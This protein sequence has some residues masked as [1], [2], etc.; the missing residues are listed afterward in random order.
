MLSTIFCKMLLINNRVI[1]IYVLPVTNRIKTTL[2]R[3]TSVILDGWA[4]IHTIF[5][6]VMPTRPDMLIRGYA[7]F[8]VLRTYKYVLKAYT[9][10]LAYRRCFFCVFSS[11]NFNF[12]LE[13][14]F[15]KPTAFDMTL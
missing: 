6:Y 15:D 10:A 5:T 14:M 2:W 9:K 11:A 3:I 1:V 4:D 7:P 8:N 13:F 12:T